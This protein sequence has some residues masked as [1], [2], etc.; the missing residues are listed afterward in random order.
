MKPYRTTISKEEVAKMPV[1]AYPGKIIVIDCPAQM[2]KAVKRLYS[3][4]YVGFDTETRPNFS[5]YSNHKVALIQIATDD[6]CYLF[7]L[8]LLHGI[9]QPLEEFLKN[10]QVMK[11]GLSLLDDFHS[12]RKLIPIENQGYVDLQKIVPSFGIQEASLQ[13]IYAILFGKKISKRARL[14]NWE[15]DKLTPPMQQYAALD[16]WACLRIYQYL[17]KIS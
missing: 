8:N 7:R 2:E 9:P 17:N 13:K 1:E 3:N 11:I 16:A 5:K 14:S 12:L 15:T 6:I 4:R 10:E